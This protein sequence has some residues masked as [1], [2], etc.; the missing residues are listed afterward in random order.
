MALI[1]FDAKTNT[2]YRTGR[3]FLATPKGE[4]SQSRYNTLQEAIAQNPQI[5]VENPDSGKV[6]SARLEEWGSNLTLVSAIPDDEIESD[7]GPPL[8]VISLD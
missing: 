4:T 1:K 7:L 8:K 5:P 3:G 2:W 6:Q